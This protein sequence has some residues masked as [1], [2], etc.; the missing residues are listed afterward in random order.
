MVTN[1]SRRKTAVFYGKST[2]EKPKNAQN[3]SRFYAT[4]KLA[5]WV[6]DEEDGAW[7]KLYDEDDEV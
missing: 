5:A 6:Y 3:G 7:T 2:D 1:D 4:D